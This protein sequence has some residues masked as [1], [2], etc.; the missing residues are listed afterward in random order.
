[1]NYNGV[2]IVWLK[3]SGFELIS[4]DKIVCIDP[5]VETKDYADII[6]ITHD[7]YDHFSPERIREIIKEDTIVVLP[8]SLKGKEDPEW[9]VVFVSPGRI[10]KRDNIIITVV[11]AYNI[12]KH[13][14]K[15]GVCMGYIIEINGVK[16]YH[17]GDTDLIPE[18]KDIKC[19]IA[20]LPVGGTYTMDAKDAAKAAKIIHPKIAIPMHYGSIVGTKDDAEKFKEYLKGTDIDVVIL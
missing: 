13:Y 16:I 20:L 18:M 19:D 12:N 2:E 15:K 1:M 3:H 4:K 6:L 7:H 9:N 5:Y 17:A 11:D 10:I 8:E 14:H